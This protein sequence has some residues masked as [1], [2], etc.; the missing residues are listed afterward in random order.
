MIVAIS[1]PTTRDVLF[2]SVSRS[3][4]KETLNNNILHVWDTIDDDTLNRIIAM[5]GRPKYIVMDSFSYYKTSINIPVYYV[6]AWIEHQLKEFES[7]D[8]IQIDNITTNY[9]SNFLINKKQINRFLAIKFCEIFD[10]N[11]NYTW[12]CIDKKFDLTHLI[13]EKQQLDDSLI[14]QHWKEILS[15]ISKFK[16][17]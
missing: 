2:D 9:T 13:Q 14:D 5:Y 12:S 17:R 4:F 6:D 16:K 3:V 15:P 7:I 8:V 10:I 11:P 1:F